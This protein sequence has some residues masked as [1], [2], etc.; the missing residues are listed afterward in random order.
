MKKQII[1]L[2]LIL[3]LAT[4]RVFG[5]PE[6]RVSVGLLNTTDVQR[7]VIEADSGKYEVFGDRSLIAKIKD[8]ESLHLDVSGTKIIVTDSRGVI[9]EF[10]EVQFVGQKYINRFNLY[11]FSPQLPVRSYDDDLVVRVYDKHLQLINKVAIQKYVAGVVLSESG[12]NASKEYYK[13]QAILARTYVIRNLNRHQKEFFQVCDNT[14]CQAYKTRDT[15]RT[16][17]W[18]A[19]L[20]TKGVVVTDN[21]QRPIEALYHA[22]SGGQTANSENVWITT[23]PYLRSVDDPFSVNQRQSTWRIDTIGVK[24]WRDY[25]HQNYFTEIDTLT[26]D[27]FVFEQEHRKEYYVVGTDSL[28]LTQIRKDWNLRST[29]FSIHPKGDGRHLIFEGKGYGHGV[30]MS[31]EGAMNMAD[32][33]YPYNEIIHYYY[34]NVKLTPLNSLRGY[35]Q[36]V[37]E[38][39]QRGF[40]KRLFN[41]P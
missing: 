34:K 22:N 11:P 15:L 17:I 27:E 20:E 32:S 13:T 36:Y 6:N 16:T 28:R 30:G 21:T 8:F 37:W 24:S 29:F 1:S 14:H 23:Q 31:Q 12:I 5:Q 19:V 2:I 35:K 9:G 4:P 39:P 10:N 41:L 40:F 26:A 25:L 3:V 38:E 7:V 18:D 33:G